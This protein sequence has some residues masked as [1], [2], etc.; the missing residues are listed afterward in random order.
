MRGCSRSRTGAAV[1]NAHAFAMR[2][3]HNIAVERFRRA[4]VVRMDQ[5][6]RLDTLDPAD[7]SPR[8]NARYW[9]APS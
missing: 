4:E 9:P 7:E 5:A 6:L 2:T 1:G 3:I 8:P